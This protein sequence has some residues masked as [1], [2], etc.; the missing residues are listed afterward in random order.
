MLGGV[1]TVLGTIVLALLLPKFV[2]YDGRE[3]IKRKKLFE[4]SGFSSIGAK[5][6]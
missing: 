2:A 6:L 3:G 1:L 5:C 4:N